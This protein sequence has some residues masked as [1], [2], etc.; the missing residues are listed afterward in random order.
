MTARA[1][2][3]SGENRRQKLGEMKFELKNAMSWRKLEKIA[4]RM[5]DVML[6]ESAGSCLSD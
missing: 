4:L 3:N 2:E 6:I 1:V 5:V